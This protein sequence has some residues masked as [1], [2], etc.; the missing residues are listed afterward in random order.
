MQLILKQ[1]W[2]NVYI[3]EERK[4][5]RKRW[6]EERKERIGNTL[7]VKGIQQFFLQFCNFLLSLK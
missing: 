3:Y 6:R 4:K 2:G 5:K 1:F 7:N